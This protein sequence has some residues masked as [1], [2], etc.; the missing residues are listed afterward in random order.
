M[1]AKTE[2][3]VGLFLVI[4]LVLA[5]ALVINFSKGTNQIGRAH[6]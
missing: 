2:W 6:V 4:S 1:K 5:A 3:K